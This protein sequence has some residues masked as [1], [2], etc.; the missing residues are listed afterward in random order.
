VLRTRW[1]QCDWWLCDRAKPEAQGDQKHHIDLQGHDLRDGCPPTIAE[2]GV[3][4]EVTNC[5]DDYS[6]KH[7][8]TERYQ[9]LLAPDESLNF[10]W[11]GC[12]HG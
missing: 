7:A 5:P 4:Y 3:E 9:E 2:Q 10:I 12:D 11:S 6:G 1:L 8:A